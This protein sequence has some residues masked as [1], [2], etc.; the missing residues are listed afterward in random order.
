MQKYS[1]DFFDQEGR[2][3]FSWGILIIF[4]SVKDR[5][6]CLFSNFFLLCRLTQEV[7]P[8]MHSTETLVLQG[9]F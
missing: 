7:S 4:P 9:G 6:I 1:V 5:L 8:K 2:E 3:K